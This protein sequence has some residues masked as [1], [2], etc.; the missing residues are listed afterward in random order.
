[1][2]HEEAGWALVIA[3]YYLFTFV[4]PVLLVGGAVYGAY[5]FGK[6]KAANKVHAAGNGQQDAP[7]PTGTSIRCVARKAGLGPC[8]IV[9]CRNEGRCMANAVPSTGNSK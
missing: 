1:M 3:A 7:G 2:T 5:W 6:R 8:P 4:V 9:S